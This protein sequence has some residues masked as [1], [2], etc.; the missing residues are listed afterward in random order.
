MP[1]AVYV[2]LLSIVS[3]VLAFAAVGL[4]AHWGEVFPRWI[5]V[6]RGRAVPV[7]GALAPAAAG[8]TVLTLLWTWAAVA[9]GLGR[10]VDGSRV[11]GPTVLE[12]HDW[13]GWAA[14]LA[15]APLLLW[16][17]LLG[18]LTIGYWRRRRCPRPPTADRRPP[19][20]EH[21]AACG[22]R[23]RAGQEIGLVR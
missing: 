18:A 19:I 17:P 15:Y 11:T 4:V 21:G 9:F 12:L 1:L 16:G 3:E 14:V 10:R 2:V 22:P 13:Q 6:L 8:A 23:S 7:L 5:P 20:G